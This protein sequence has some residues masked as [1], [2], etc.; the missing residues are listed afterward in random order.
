MYVAPLASSV[1]RVNAIGPGPFSRLMSVFLFGILKLSCRPGSKK[2]LFIFSMI[3]FSLGLPKSDPVKATY[4]DANVAMGIVFVGYM[5]VF[6][7]Q[8]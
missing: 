7:S 5:S 1:L 8:Y 3:C 6:Q 4:F 2:Y